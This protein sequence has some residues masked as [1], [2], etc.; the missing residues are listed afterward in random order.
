M[1]NGIAYSFGQRA[2]NQAE[3]AYDFYYEIEI[4]KELPFKGQTG[5]V[6]P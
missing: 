2:L 4:L 1:S 3:N 5:D 6:I